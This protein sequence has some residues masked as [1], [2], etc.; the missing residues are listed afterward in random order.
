LVCKTCAR[1]DSSGHLAITSTPLA[2]SQFADNGAAVLTSV[3]PGAVV[4]LAL[5]GWCSALADNIAC[6]K[7]SVVMTLDGLWSRGTL[8][9]TSLSSNGSSSASI[10]CSSASI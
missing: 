7:K 2:L 5:L 10:T 9:L 1:Q 4:Q 6:L 3:T 8:E